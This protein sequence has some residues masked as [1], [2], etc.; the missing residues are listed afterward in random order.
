MTPH[1]FML[2]LG[3]DGVFNMAV[4]KLLYFLMFKFGHHSFLFIQIPWF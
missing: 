4:L 2:K 1:H 3:H